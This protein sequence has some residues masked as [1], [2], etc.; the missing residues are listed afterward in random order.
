MCLGLTVLAH[1]V[2]VVRG[3]VGLLLW[4]LFSAPYFYKAEF[5]PPSQGNKIK[6]Q[7]NQQTSMQG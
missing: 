6:P 1:D 3:S 5:H 7:I 4:V 2:G